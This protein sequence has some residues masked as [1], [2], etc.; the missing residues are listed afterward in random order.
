MVVLAPWLAPGDLLVR[1]LVALRDPAWTSALLTGGTRL[2]RDVPGEVLAALLGQV[3]GGAVVVRLAL[4]G[5]CAAL[6]A[7]TGR[8]LERL[9]LP[10]VAVGAVAAVHNPWTWAHLRAGQWLVVV[11][12]AAV[13]WVVAH[14]AADDRWSLAAVVVAASV[15]GFLAVA[16]VWPTLVLATV[17]A[18]RW[19]AL[20]V[21]AAAAGAAAL[22]WLVLG[23]PGDVDPDGFAAFAARADTPFGTLGSVLSAGG[24]FNGDIASPWRETVLL[25]GLATVLA[26]ACVVA[27]VLHV[28]RRVP[29]RS[30][31]VG[32]LGAAALAVLVAV[33]GATTAGLA[34]LVDLA[35]AVPALAAVRDTHRLLAPLVVVLAMGA[36]VLVARLGG[37]LGAGAGVGAVAVGLLVL[38]LPD[39]L[40]GPR[41]PG[42]STLP[43][44]WHEAAAT[45]DADPRPGV[46]LVVPAGQTQQYP[47]TD[48]RPVAVPLRRAAAREVVGAPE[49]R[50]GELVVDDGTPAQPWQGLAELPPR[51]WNADAVT[52]SSVGWIAITDP[53]VLPDPAVL[54][55]GFEVV[56][57]APSLVLLRVGGDPAPG[58]AGAPRW[59]VALD[60][61]VLVAAVALW[62][63]VAAG[64]ARGP[65]S[66]PHAGRPSRPGRRARG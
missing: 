5:A 66:L 24:Y 49:L 56:V 11:A 10:A 22:P 30:A 63:V 54:A 32:L 41:L 38:A 2:A 34:V 3:L 58:P 13:P 59:L 60:L 1:D 37:R 25:G 17:A 62:G 29:W 45:V 39:P 33:L 27:A 6:G 42:P 31:E 46:V 18:R 19:A 44:A 7:G 4:L 28:R 9:P 35:D 14:V 61:T 12:L 51:T 43:Q 65:A 8:L 20:A 36:A 15:S 57:D 52:A 16:V 40:V 50:V 48:G 55:D 23:G 26:V 64:R 21:G 47:F 53:G